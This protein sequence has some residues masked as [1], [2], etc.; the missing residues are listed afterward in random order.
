MDKNSLPKGFE[1]LKLDSLLKKT[2]L[3]NSVIENGKNINANIVEFP[4]V[5]FLSTF[6]KG[7]EIVGEKIY[8]FQ[9][10]KGR[11]LVLT[12]DSLA[13][14]L[15]YYASSFDQS[16]QERFAWIS[17]TFRYRNTASRFWLQL[18]F[19]SVNYSAS[20]SLFELAL[21]TR[22]LIKVIQQNTDITV[23]LRVINPSLIKEVIAQ[24]LQ[25]EYSSKNLFEK[26]RTSGFTEQI[27]LFETEL[28]DG[29]HKEF[30]LH[31]LR[32]G[33]TDHRNFTIE[34]IEGNYQELRNVKLFSDIVN[35]D[36]S[37][38]LSVDLSSKHS[39]EI[40]S[41]VSFIIEA[42]GEQ[43]I[44][45]GGLYHHYASYFSDTI[46]TVASVC[47]GLGIMPLLKEVSSMLVFQ[48]KVLVIF[49]ESS[50]TDYITA[51]KLND[52]LISRGLCTS[53]YFVTSISRKI[54]KKL[55]QKEKYRWCCIVEKNQ[56]GK[57]SGKLFQP[58]S[59]NSQQS[60]SAKTV[61]EFVEIFAQE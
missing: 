5:S 44:G 10:R 54:I 30:L 16:K 14:I 26:W 2:R 20:E 21:I 40:T 8:S 38:K 31:I 50:T 51:L 7:A 23:S 24:N 39:S 29:F 45:D 48:R 4:P 59:D 57:I 13:H 37:I 19:A 25:N 6:T 42:E 53:I 43:N 12:P 1:Y 28:F 49:Y 32:S 47:V 33:V 22:T 11:N 46:S 55:S 52:I 15:N 18:G 34:G 3:I 27:E 56:D 61:S 36:E 41:G 17:P 58:D 35:F 9:D 60:F